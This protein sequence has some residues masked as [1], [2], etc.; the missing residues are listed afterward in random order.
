[1]K[2]VRILGLVCCTL[3]PLASFAQAERVLKADE[4]NERALVDILSAEPAITPARRKTRS[5]NVV[6]DE[7]S[8]PGAKPPSASLLIVF[9]TSSAGLTPAGKQS[10]DVVGRA[11]NSD[12]LTPF[13]FAIEGH[14][15]PRGGEDYNL[16]L[17]QARA[18]SVV[19]YLSENYHIDRG[20][21]KPV[22]KGPSELLNPARPE[23]PENRRVTIKRLDN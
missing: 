22:G 17:S 6:R 10:L 9:E 7:S 15:D 8:L 21:L 18:E 14:T 19:G 3:A 20:R 5:I 16:R 23:A 11:L 13:R 12:K 2:Y 1:M 4:I